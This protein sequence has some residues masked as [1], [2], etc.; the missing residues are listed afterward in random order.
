MTIEELNNVSEK[1]KK[2]ILLSCGGSTEWVNKML[3]VFPIHD[4]ADLQEKAKEKWAQLSD[5]DW[6]EAFSMHPKIGDIHSLKKKFAGTAAWA[7]NEQSGMNEAT[8]AVIEALANGNTEY[9]EKFGYI[10][11]VFATGKS[12]NEMLYMLQSRLQNEPEDELKIAA[13]EQVKITDLRL[14]KLFT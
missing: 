2:N 4:L 13:A 3:S 6:L 7:S 11:I 14:A 12:A 8:D 10:F 5:E 1:E 9:E